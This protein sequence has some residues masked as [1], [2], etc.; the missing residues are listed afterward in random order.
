MYATNPVIIAPNTP[1]RIDSLEIGP[2]I[3]GF[4]AAGWIMQSVGVKTI[5]ES[6]FSSGRPATF[7]LHRGGTVASKE[8]MHLHGKTGQT[9]VTTR[10]HFS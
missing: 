4:V 2:P 10:L 1:M 7:F 6:Q 9:V 5:I 8:A 3:I